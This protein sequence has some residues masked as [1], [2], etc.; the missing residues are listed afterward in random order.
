T[1]PIPPR[2]I[3]ASPMRWLQTEYLLKGIYLGLVLY[4]ALM[5]A[6]IPPD[7]GQTL[8]SCLLRVN[9][10]GLAG[11]ALALLL[12]S[13]VRLREGYHIRGRVVA[14]VLFLLLESPTLAYLGILAGTVTGIYLARG[15]LNAGHQQALQQLLVP[16]LGGAAVAGLA[17]GL[18]RHVQH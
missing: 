10:A 15:L 16:I 3:P 5:A 7:D 13:L 17:F 9:L 8:Y 18:L 1:R 4:A 6:A 11:L 14:Y 12:A 2:E